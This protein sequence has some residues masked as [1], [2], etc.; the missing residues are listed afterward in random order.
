VV[1]HD[2]RSDDD[3]HDDESFLG[4]KIITSPLGS[5]VPSV[6]RCAFIP[7]ILYTP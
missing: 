1:L 3:L 4:E 7:I 2:V 5:K 6:V